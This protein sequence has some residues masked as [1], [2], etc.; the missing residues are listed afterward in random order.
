VPDGQSGRFTL[1]PT[2]NIHT[3]ILLD[4]ETGDAWHV[5]WGA[6]GDRFV[7]PI[8]EPPVRAIDNEAEEP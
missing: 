5:Q 6:A 4:Q 8:A 1:Y 3:F 2:K 7:L